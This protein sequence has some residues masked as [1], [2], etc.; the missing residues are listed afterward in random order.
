MPRNNRD[1]SSRKSRDSLRRRE[2]DLGYYLIVT[3]AEHTEENYVLGL[4]N[5]LPEELHGRIVIKT[6]QSR[7]DKIVSRAKTLASFNPQ[8]AETWIVFDR[9]RVMNFDKIISQAEK[10]EIN[11]GWSNPCLEIWFDAYFGTMHHYND[12]VSCCRGFARTFERITMHR[13][14]KNTR[15]IYSLL[16]Q[17]GDEENAV[18]IAENRYQQHLREGKQF[19]S[20]MCPCTTVYQL[21]GEIKNRASKNQNIF[22]ES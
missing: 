10:E 4:R 18:R 5:S 3:D 16:T 19:P 14:E 6:E 7:L 22:S 15:D 1:G 13:Y 11:V 8:Y 20:E 9:D 12:S 2:P 17:F 21:V